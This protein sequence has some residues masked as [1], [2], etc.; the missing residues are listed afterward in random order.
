VSGMDGAC[1]CGRMA[2]R[3]HC[4]VK[5]RPVDTVTPVGHGVLDAFSHHRDRG[6]ECILLRIL[7]DRSR[8][9]AAMRPQSQAHHPTRPQSQAHRPT[10]P[11]SALRCHATAVAGSHRPRQAPGAVVL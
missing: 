7:P 11:Q 5:Q 8:R 9:C 1:D 3:G 4:G 6:I 10:R 2:A